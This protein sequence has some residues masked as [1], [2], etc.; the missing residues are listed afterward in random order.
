MARH[1][2]ALPRLSLPASVCLCVNQTERLGEDYLADTDSLIAMCDISV[3]DTGRFLYAAF[4]TDTNTLPRYTFG[5]TLVILSSSMAVFA[6]R[7]ARGLV[8]Y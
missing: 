3:R 2:T 4:A 8:W 7:E 1:A 6:F 5:G